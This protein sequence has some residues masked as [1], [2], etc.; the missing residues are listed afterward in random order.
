MVF[1]P[2]TRPAFDWYES[3]LTCETVQALT[4]KSAPDWMASE[5]TAAVMASD[6]S[7]S[8]SIEVEPTLMHLES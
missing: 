5:R 1:L 2:L 8:V 3:R 6:E 4:T 7:S